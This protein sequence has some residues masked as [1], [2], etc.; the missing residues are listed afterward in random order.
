MTEKPSTPKRLR[1]ILDIEPYPT[2]LRDEFEVTAVTSD[3]RYRVE[4]SPT[5]T[6]Q[7]RDEGRI[8][9]SLAVRIVPKKEKT[10]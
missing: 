3:S 8:A 2:D 10:R 5:V 7:Y 9:I 1:V 4:P 6:G